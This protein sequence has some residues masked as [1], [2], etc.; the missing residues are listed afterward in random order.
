MILAEAHDLMDLLLD[1]ADQPYFTTE[2]K[3]KFLN[4][5]IS[6]FINFHYQKMTADEDSRRALAGCIDWQAFHLTEAEIISGNYIHVGTYPALS[7]KYTDEGIPSDPNDLPGSTYTNV[8]WGGMGYFLYGH[9]Y[10]LPKQHLYVLSIGIQYYNQDDII[11]P[12]TGLAYSGVTED[13]VVISPTVSVKNKSTRD[14]Y[15]HA[16]TDDPFNESGEDAPYWT[17]IENRLVFSNSSAIRYINMQVIILPSVQQA[18]SEDT[19]QES[20]APMRLTF[21]AHYQKQIVQMAVRKMSAN[22]EST[23]YP[24]QQFESQV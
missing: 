17:Y 5:A 12:S 2:E 20:T 14:Y 18:F 7:A 19:Y 8:P 10:V 23:N 15:E 4:L 13:D 22:V 6:D 1:K 11:D 21:A 3:D 24:Q 9:Q 16:Y